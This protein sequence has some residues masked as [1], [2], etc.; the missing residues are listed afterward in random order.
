M[1]DLVWLE[2][3]YLFSDRIGAGRRFARLVPWSASFLREAAGS[4]PW[5]RRRWIYA[6]QEARVH[7]W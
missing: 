7:T 2:C 5:R 4:W 6:S 3:W 1:D